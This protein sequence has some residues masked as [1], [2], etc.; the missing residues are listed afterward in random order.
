M[1]QLRSGEPPRKG[2]VVHSTVSYAILVPVKPTAE[3]RRPNDHRRACPGISSCQKSDNMQHI[4]RIATA[5]NFPLRSLVGNLEMSQQKVKEKKKPPPAK[6]CKL[7]A[8]LVRHTSGEEIEK[9]KSKRRDE[10]RGFE[11]LAYRCLFES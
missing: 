10:S 3:A 9:V 8:R 1:A 11:S 5:P 6:A 2:F 7:H 4:T